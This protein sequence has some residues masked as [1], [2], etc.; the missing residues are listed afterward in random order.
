MPLCQRRYADAAT[1]EELLLPSEEL[2]VET[3]LQ[4][5]RLSVSMGGLP[6]LPDSQAPWRPGWGNSVALCT[7][8]RRENVTDVR[9]WLLYHKCVPLRCR[10]W[11]GDRVDVARGMTDLQ[12]T[13]IRLLTS[14][15]M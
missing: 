13:S 5:E 15:A 4:A 14:T 7:T 11:G 6:K 10:S 8:M 9:E 3:S 12:C 1:D 2:P